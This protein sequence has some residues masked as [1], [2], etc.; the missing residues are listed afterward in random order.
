MDEK[1]RLLLI[2]IIKLLN[3]HGPDSF[4]SLSKTISDGLFLSNL[5]LIL[6]EIAKSDKDFSIVGKRQQTTKYNIRKQLLEL[7]QKQPEKGQILVDFYNGL[8]DKKYL[9]NLRDIREFADEL[10]LPA[11]KATSRDRA[12]GPLMR[13]LMNLQLSELKPALMEI[14][15]VDSENNDRS[16]AGWSKLI[17]NGPRHPQHDKQYSPSSAPESD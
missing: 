7:T 1:V 15:E 14:Y 6:T 8:T 9:R 16:L 2:D 10:K 13:G 11:V 3:K 4:L 17:L 5:E 12:L